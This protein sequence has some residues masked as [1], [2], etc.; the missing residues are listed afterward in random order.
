MDQQSPVLRIYGKK[1][2]QRR[3]TW[4]HWLCFD[5]G[6]GGKGI[7]IFLGLNATIMPAKLKGKEAAAQPAIAGNQV[8]RNV[9]DSW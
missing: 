9:G 2:D 5:G 7:I 3:V 6:K 4:C 8:S 1:I